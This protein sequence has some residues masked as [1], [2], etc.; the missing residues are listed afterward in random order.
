MSAPLNPGGAGACCAP[1]CST[2]PAYQIPGPAGV[3]A[4]T[5]TTALFTMPA[6]GGTVLVDVENSIWVGAASFIFIEGAGYFE[7][8]SIPDGTHVLLINTGYSGNKAPSQNIPA[9]SKVVAGGPGGNFGNAFTTTTGTFTMPAVSSNVTVGVLTSEWTTPGAYVFITTAGFFKV[10]SVPDSSSLELENLGYPDN[11]VPTTV[12]NSGQQV[13]PTGPRGAAGATG[14]TVLNDISPTRFKG[15][16]IV[17]NGSNSPTGAADVRL[18]VGSDGKALVADSSQATGLNYATITPNSAAT[19]SD[20][21]VFDGTSGTPCKLKDSKLLITSD[22]ALQSTP[23][24][25]NARGSK[26]VDLQVSRSVVTQ[27]ASGQSSGILAGENNTASGLDATVAGGKQNTASGQASGV[28]AGQAN[29]ASATNAFVGGGNNNAA[30]NTGA[31]VGSGV[32]NT[33]SGQYS[34]VASGFDN[35]ASGDYSSVA[36][37]I[38]NVA[39]GSESNVAGGG[40]NTAS[41]TASAVTGG[42]QANARLYGQISH[43]AGQFG[44]Q[45]DSQ[46]TELIWRI[47]TTDATANV[48]AFLDGSAV[49]A[50]IPT[51]TTWGF[52]ILVVGRSSAGVSAMWRVTGAIQNN[53]GTVTL[54]AAVTTSVLADGTGSTWGVAGS[55]AVTA[56]NTN[57]SLKI[58]VTGAAA[59]NIRWTAHARI[60]E[61]GY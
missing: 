9:H 10:I 44:S 40:S 54:T 27:V 61:L 29:S 11:A 28:A 14:T 43:S 6:V 36:S 35:T 46:L 37:G 31:S 56:D 59:T 5:F 45:G 50:V 25:G 26:A 15:D 51:N 32:D 42:L 30:S 60:V 57:K 34:S 12:I 7:V 13:V 55:V 3:N 49:R 4:Y 23:T 1:Q 2:A 21:A 48:E 17:D 16:L 58:A 38:G 8:S 47:A 19:D 33:A 52:D 39:S 24:G 53:S 20:I 41:A 22:G 18:G